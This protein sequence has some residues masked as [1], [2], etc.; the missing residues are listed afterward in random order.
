[1]LGGRGLHVPG[2]R[3]V[4]HEVLARNLRSA[5]RPDMAMVALLAS[6]AVKAANV[7][8]I[9]VAGATRAG[10]HGRFGHYWPALLLRWRYGFLAVLAADVPGLRGHLFSGHVRA[11]GDRDRLH[12]AGGRAPDDM[13]KLMPT[14]PFAHRGFVTLGIFSFNEFGCSGR[15]L[16]PRC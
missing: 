9:H 1:M 3:I 13:K 2:R 16:I 8:V 5:A 10:P 7:P 6:F 4:G 12:V 15:D 11:G 14:P